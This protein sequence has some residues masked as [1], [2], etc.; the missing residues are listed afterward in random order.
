[1]FYSEGQG[2]LPSA[3]IF[4]NRQWDVT[5][6][7]A[8][9]SMLGV[10]TAFLIRL[11]KMLFGTRMDNVGAWL[12][13]KSTIFIKHANMLCLLYCFHTITHKQPLFAVEKSL[14]PSVWD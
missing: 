8:Q 9:Y 14:S 2:N 10:T 7:L 11:H 12:S 5:N 13:I 4:K 3:R 1:M 6:F